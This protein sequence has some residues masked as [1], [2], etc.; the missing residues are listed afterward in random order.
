LLAAGLLIFQFTRKTSV[1]ANTTAGAD[2]KSIAVLPFDNLSS[3]K[4]NA[5]FRAGHSG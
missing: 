1:T 3:D 2:S 5:F 4:E